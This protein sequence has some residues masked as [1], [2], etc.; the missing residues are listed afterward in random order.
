MER[1]AILPAW[2]R[3]TLVAPGNRRIMSA[4]DAAN[5]GTQLDADHVPET[6]G[7]MSVCRR[8]G[9]RT[10]SP[11]GQHHRPHEQQLVRSNR[12]LDT[13]VQRRRIENARRLR[14]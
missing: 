2:L 10:D 5:V 13:E 8:C 12:W 3:P 6:N 11:L 9:A 14:N 4:L 7:R 1:V